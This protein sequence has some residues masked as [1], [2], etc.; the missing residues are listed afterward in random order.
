[1]IFM[2][3]KNKTPRWYF[4]LFNDKL[5]KYTKKLYIIKSNWNLMKAVRDSISS[6][7]ARLKEV[8]GFG[9]E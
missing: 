8:L 2:K 3:S 9:D 6:S 5:Y 7:F 4:K 1:M